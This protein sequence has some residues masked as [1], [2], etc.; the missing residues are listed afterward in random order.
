V[1][2]VH[3]AASTSNLIDSGRQCYMNAGQ[4][5]TSWPS[6]HPPALS[7]VGVVGG[8]GPIKFWADQA[9]IMFHASIRRSICCGANTSAA[10]ELFPSLTKAQR[11]ATDLAC[12]ARSCV[13]ECVW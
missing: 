10:F 1:T 3:A 2:A 6:Q 5:V 12:F 8:S 4:I 11:C 13:V 7:V 9:D